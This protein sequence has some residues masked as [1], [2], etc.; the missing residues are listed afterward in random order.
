MAWA[1]S[2]ADGE[3]QFALVGGGVP[4][5]PRL[6]GGLRRAADDDG[7]QALAPQPLRGLL[8]VVQRH[9]VDDGVALLDIVDRQL[10]ELVLQ[11]RA[12]ELGGGVERQHLR[13]LEVGLRLVQLLL[14]RAFLGDAADFLVDRIEVSPARSA[15]VPVLP[16]NSA[17]CSIQSSDSYTE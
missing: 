13:A 12:G 17:E 2:P 6:R 16:M 5:A 8:G 11:Q 3:A 4:G 1:R 7:E 10:V 14:G 15:R 9:R